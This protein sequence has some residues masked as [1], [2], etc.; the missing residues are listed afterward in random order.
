[1][2]RIIL[3]VEIPALSSLTWYKSYLIFVDINTLCY[4][5]F[6]VLVTSSEC[7]SQQNAVSSRWF[8]RKRNTA[9]STVGDSREP[10][11]R[12]LYKLWWM[13]CTMSNPY[14][15]IG[16]CKFSCY[17]FFFRWMPVLRTMCWCLQATGITQKQAASTLGN[18]SFNKWDCLHQLPGCG[19][20]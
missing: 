1:M 20:P 8:Q 6:Q 16:S 7:T 12:N 11:Y 19:M 9:S 18:K 13:H 4:Q 10:V 17:R 15:Q 14:H 3:N 2:A 5:I